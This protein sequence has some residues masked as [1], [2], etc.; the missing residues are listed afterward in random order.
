MKNTFK[1]FLVFIEVPFL[2]FFGLN[3]FQFLKAQEQKPNIIFIMTDVITYI[4]IQ[5]LKNRD[6]KKPFFLMH[7][8]KAPHGMFEYAPRYA[9]FLKEKEIPEPAS[10]YFKYPKL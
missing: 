8:Y 10:L 7:H 9:D 2:L 5:Y 6:K 4:S 1:T 3:S